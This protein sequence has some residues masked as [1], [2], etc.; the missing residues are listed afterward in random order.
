M[1][2]GAR[3]TRLGIVAATI[4][5]AAGA[6][7]SAEAWAA[8]GTAATASKPKRCTNF[9]DFVATNCELTWQGITVY[10]IVDMGGPLPD[11]RR[12]VRSALLCRSLISAPAS[13]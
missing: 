5:A 1:R 2:Q 13:E 11:P 10:G 7:C 3:I 12:A 4:L 9:W 8:D 6:V